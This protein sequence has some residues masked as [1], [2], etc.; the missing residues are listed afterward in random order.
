MD[1]YKKD[2]SV[3]LCVR[4]WIETYNEE[5]EMYEGT[6]LPLREGVD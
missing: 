1:S 5:T 3:S 2:E 4:E 6:G